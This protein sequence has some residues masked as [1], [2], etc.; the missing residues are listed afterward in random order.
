MTN[1]TIREV[2]PFCSSWEMQVRALSVHGRERKNEPGPVILGKW[3]LSDVCF[4]FWK[5][6]SGHQ[7]VCRSSLR[8]VLSLDVTCESRSLF[9]EIW[10]HK[11]W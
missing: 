2:P 11:S 3:S 1:P 10:W 6:L 8:L 4:N 7:V 9:L 5:L